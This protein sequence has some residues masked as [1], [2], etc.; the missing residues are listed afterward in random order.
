MDVQAILQLGPKLGEFLEQFSDCGG[1]EVQ[2][3][4]RTYVEGQVSLI[5]RKNIE[6]IALHADKVPRTLQEFLASYE[7]DHQ[8]MQNRIQEI[9]ARDHARKNSVGIIDETSFAKKGDRTPGIQRQWCGESGKTDNCSV[10]VHLSYAGDDFHCLVDED[11][12]L[13]ESW[14]DD[15]ARCRAAKIPDEVVYRPK[16]EIALEQHQRATANGIVFDW[17][18]FDEWYGSKPLFLETLDS[19]KQAFVGEIPRNFR[20]WMDKP[21]VTSRPYRKGSRGKGRKTPRLLAETPKTKT[22][23]QCFEQSAVLADQE[24][25]RW[26]VKDTQKGPKVVDVKRAIVYRKNEDGLPSSANH[27]VVVREVTSPNKLK[28]FLSNAQ[29]KTELG[30][31]LKCAYSRWR[32]ER[33]FQDD[34]S[35]V[36]LNQFEGRSYPGLMRHLILSAVS[37]LFLARM[38]ET[39]LTWYPELTVSQMKQAM[40]ALIDSM[41]LTPASAQ[42]VLDLA[43]RKLTYYQRRNEQAR[44]SHTKTRNRKLAEIGV[45]LST[46]QKCSWDTG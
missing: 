41:F 32:V 43:A 23:E 29:T 36:G 46:I 27:L 42:R 34:K 11:L 7:W 1:G 13:P 33:C 44:K 10:T 37:L 5:D 45:D 4:V 39:F 38:R 18:T 28:Y 20:V 16:S 2:A 9:V 24:W 12:F 19:R 35:Y 3:H 14:S 8:G 31:I 6:Q 15:R 22:V 17:L 30:P 21:Q 26:H 25:E 40:S